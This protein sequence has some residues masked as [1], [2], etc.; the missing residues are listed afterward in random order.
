M[1]F[2]IGSDNL[3]DNLLNEMIRYIEENLCE[4]IDYQD[5]S[6]IVGI[7]EYSLQRIFVFLTGIS[8]S[9]YIRKRR[10]S[11]AFEEIKR[12]NSKII[13]IAVKYHYDSAISFSRAFKQ[14]FNMTPTECRNNDKSYKLLPIIEFH[15]ES[16]ICNE[17]N[18]EIKEIEEKTLY[19]FEVNA[20]EHEDLL[21]KIR[22][23]YKKLKDESVYDKLKDMGMYGISICKEDRYEYYVG[24]ELKLENTQMIKIEKG[25][26]AIFEVGSNEQ[27]DI[28]KTYDFVYN[29]WL[30]STNYELLDKPEIE[31]YEEDNC[32]LYFQIKDKQN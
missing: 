13:D 17:L 6:K 11:K 20:E 18:Y 4:D 28:V 10:L 14:Y 24:S 23:L 5:L 15:K 32:Y 29:K 3:E 25:K 9:E 21:Y 31:C 19:C 27:K 12:T 2:Y 26:Y 7:S 16:N 1:L 8:I 22:E 30:K